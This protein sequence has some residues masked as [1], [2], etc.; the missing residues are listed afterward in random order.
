MISAGILDP[1]VQ[2]VH[3][4]RYSLSADWNESRLCELRKRLGS[5]APPALPELRPTDDETRAQREAETFL[6]AV[7]HGATRR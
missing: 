5:G 6:R 7:R 4:I 1:L 2:A 3:E